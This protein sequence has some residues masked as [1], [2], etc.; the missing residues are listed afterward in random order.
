LAASVDIEQAIEARLSEIES[1]LESYEELVRERDRLRR[2]LQELNGE[3]SRSPRASSAPAVGNG[4][5]AGARRRRSSRRAKRGS[6]VAAITSYVAEHPGSTAAEIAAGT[7]IDRSVVYSATSRL[8]GAGRL[9]RKSKGD[10]Q[11]GYES[12]NGAAKSNAGA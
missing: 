8:A 3:G 2:A 12:A 9:R 11:V 4:R 5:R 10:R 7:G 1:Q 6:N